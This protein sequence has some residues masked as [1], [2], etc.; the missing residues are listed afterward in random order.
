M[1]NMR[2]FLMSL[3]LVAGTGAMTGCATASHDSYTVIDRSS[4]LEQKQP[5]PTEGMTAMQKTGYYL[6][7]ISLECLYGWAGGNPSFSP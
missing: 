5:S 7:W 6:G 4:G 3:L 2:T 1:K